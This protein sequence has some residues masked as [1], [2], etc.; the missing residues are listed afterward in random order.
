MIIIVVPALVI[1]NRGTLC[2]LMR[3][4]SEARGIEAQMA[5]ITSLE[6][7]LQTPELSSRFNETF[8]SHPPIASALEVLGGSAFALELASEIGPGL[9]ECLTRILTRR[10]LAID[11][12]RGYPAMDAAVRAART[13]TAL[14]AFAPSWK[15]FREPASRQAP[16]SREPASGQGPPLRGPASG[17]A[18]ADAIV[19]SDSDEDSEGDEGESSSSEEEDEEEEDWHIWG[20]GRRRGWDSPRRRSAARWRPS[21]TPTVQAV[22]VIDPR[23]EAIVKGDLA[24]L[25]TRTGAEGTAARVVLHADALPESLI[26]RPSSCGLIDVAAAVGGEPLRYLLAFE[27]IAPG[28]EAMHQAVASGSPD[29]VL[30]IWDRLGAETRQRH[31]AAWAETAA[32][33]HRPAILTWLL[34]DESMLVVCRLRFFAR[35]H[36]LFDALPALPEYLPSAEVPKG[37]KLDSLLAQNIA[38][39]RSLGFTLEAPKLV[40]SKGSGRFKLDE[41]C[42]AVKSGVAPT[43]F[44]VQVGDEVAGGYTAVAWPKASGRTKSHAFDHAMRGFVF[45]LRPQLRYYVQ[46]D[47]EGTTVN[48]GWKPPYFGM[49]ALLVETSGVVWCGSPHVAYGEAQYHPVIQ[50]AGGSQTVKYARWELWAV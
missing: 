37:V 32:D 3:K 25:G 47:P 48:P 43:L 44:L 20:W 46:T 12:A 41:F 11:A 7:S 13:G 18:P 45:A 31:K 1:D 38:G 9:R 30:T 34:Q 49:R 35:S 19:V 4:I 28:S 39:V 8:L 15:A 14:H 22:H 23:A 40:I 24:A 6:E 26:R 5:A 10:R 33:F 2:S 36:R 16:P 50:N 17:Q 42:D 27:Q 21:V 29:S